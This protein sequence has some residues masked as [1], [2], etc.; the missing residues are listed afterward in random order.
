MLKQIIIIIM[1]NKL[2]FFFSLSCSSLASQYGIRALGTVNGFH[3]IYSSSKTFILFHLR[4]LTFYT[5]SCKCSIRSVKLSLVGISNSAY[6]SRYGLE[7]FLLSTNS[8]P[9]QFLASSASSDHISD[10]PTA[11]ASS[12]QVL[13]NPSFLQWTH[14]DQFLLSWILSSI[15]EP[16][17]GHVIQCTSA[18]GIWK[19][20]ELLFATKSKARHLHI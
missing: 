5:C 20:L 13:V 15:P 14:L 6:R 1:M 8:K 18:Y 16:M 2:V 11:P 9:E 10:Q 7:E 17:L 19:L 4:S 3:R 12:K